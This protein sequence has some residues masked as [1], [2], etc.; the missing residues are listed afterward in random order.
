[1]SSSFYC[2][3]EKQ[4]ELTLMNT[5]QIR[6]EA[7]KIIAKLNGA[8]GKRAVMGSVPGGREHR[9]LPVLVSDGSARVREIV[10]GVRRGGV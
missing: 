6:K 10:P 8:C 2:G 7:L 5:I 4:K 3:F 9:L 1:M